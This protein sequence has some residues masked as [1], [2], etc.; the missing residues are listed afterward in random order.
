M[1]HRPF[2]HPVSRPHHA[3]TAQGVV[4]LGMPHALPHRPSPGC[5]QQRGLC[6]CWRNYSTGVWMVQEEVVFASVERSSDVLSQAKA[7]HAQ[8]I[9]HWCRAWTGCI[10]F[11]RHA[12][13]MRLRRVRRNI[14]AASRERRYPRVWLTTRLSRRSNTVSRWAGTLRVKHRQLAGV[15]TGS[16]TSAPYVKALNTYVIN[17]GRRSLHKCHASTEISCQFIIKH[18]HVFSRA[19]AV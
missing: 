15:S 18:T 13:V 8:S 12:L 9:A 7:H 16:D 10:G 14:S 1:Y 17:L 6:C 5:V 2:L 4:I 3:R 11:V 19:L